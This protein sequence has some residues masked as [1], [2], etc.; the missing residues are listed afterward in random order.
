MQTRIPTDAAWIEP[1]SCFFEVTVLRAS[2]SRFF[3]G[4]PEEIQ[5]D[6]FPREIESLKPKPGDL[7]HKLSV[8][9]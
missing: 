9:G 6:R 1:K 4:V 8:L 3:L 2:G 5:V 7:F